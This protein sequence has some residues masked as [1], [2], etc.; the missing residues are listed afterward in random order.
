MVKRIDTHSHPLKA[1]RSYDYN[2][3]MDMNFNYIGMKNHHPARITASME[4][5]K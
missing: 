3:T 4:A 1:H 5:R 2:I